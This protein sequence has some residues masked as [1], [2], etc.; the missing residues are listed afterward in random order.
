MILKHG[1]IWLIQVR[2]PFK[3]TRNL[4]DFYTIHG[5]KGVQKSGAWIENHFISIMA[6]CHLLSTGSLLSISEGNHFWWSPGMKSTSSEPPVRPV[7]PPAA[8][9]TC[10]AAFLVA[11]PTNKEGTY[12]TFLIRYS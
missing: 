5:I 4:H 3:R 1:V 10:I 8:W 12:I 11:H 9:Q 6:E 7:E 2:S